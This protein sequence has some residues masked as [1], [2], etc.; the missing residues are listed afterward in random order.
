VAPF[1]DAGAVLAFGGTDLQTLPGDLL[2]LS[3]DGGVT[4]YEVE[5]ATGLYQP[6]FFR[7]P[8]SGRNFSLCGDSTP[9][10]PGCDV[11]TLTK[12]DAGLF[13]W[14]K[15][16]VDGLVPQGRAGFAYTCDSVTDRAVVFGGDEGWVVLAP[17]GPLPP[18]RASALGEYDPLRHRFVM[19]L[20]NSTQ[21]I[22][23][24]LWALEL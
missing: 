1:G 3:P 5:G 12:V 2:G 7:H 24:D 19:G 11:L 8:S 10:R 15:V 18:P 13:R 16:G 20:G 23:N 17:E 22:F 6:G 14:A 4:S 21:G 9:A